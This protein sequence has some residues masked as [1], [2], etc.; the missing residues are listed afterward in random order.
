MVRRKTESG[1]SIVEMLGVLAIMGVITVMG[2]S[3]YSQAVARI[4]RNKMSEDI[5]RLA[6]EV[7]TVY[8]GRNDY[9]GLNMTTIM[10]IMGM[11]GTD[12]PN[13][14]GGN[15]GVG[16]TGPSGATTA[17]FWISSNNISNADC[18]Y[19][20]NMAWQDIRT[21]TGTS[22]TEPLVAASGT[23]APPTGGSNCAAAGNVFFFVYQ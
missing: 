16:T 20:R 21:S 22:A 3:G 1:R 14:F 7:R 9:A 2:I 13:P 11:S 6:Q 23:T 17:F 18:L 19:F 15:Y 10:S 5:T 12:Y 8:A 4:N